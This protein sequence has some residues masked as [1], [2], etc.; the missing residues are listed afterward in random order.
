VNRGVKRPVAIRIALVSAAAAAF[1]VTGA[2]CSSSNKQDSVYCV[3]QNRRVVD[4]Q[5]CD[6][7]H[8]YGGT[9]H[10]YYLW[11]S[12][13][14][15]NYS[16]GSVV[17]GGSLIRTNDAAGRSGVGLPGTGHVSSGAFTRGGFGGGG[18]HSSGG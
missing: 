13:G 15:Y 7:N 16:R 9:S 2:G 6:D 10:G 18:S 5:Y 11:H 14:R 17:S 1:T 8:P 4:D 3:D 12:P